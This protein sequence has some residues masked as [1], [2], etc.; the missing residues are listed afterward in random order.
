MTT[1]HE[2]GVILDP[3]WDRADCYAVAVVDGY[4]LVIEHYDR[5]T[6]EQTYEWQEHNEVEARQLRI[7]LDAYTEILAHNATAGF[8]SGLAEKVAA[9][10]RTA[11]NGASA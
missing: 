11:L 1:K 5:A 4:V 10:C 6:H 8:Y 7:V 9:E 3:N 2:L